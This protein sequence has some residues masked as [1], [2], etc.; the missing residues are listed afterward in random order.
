MNARLLSL[1]ECQAGNTDKKS[2]AEQQAALEFPLDELCPG[3]CR[4]LHGC[5]ILGANLHNCL[6]IWLLLAGAS[7]A[8]VWLPSQD[9]RTN[10]QPSAVR[11]SPMNLSA[12]RNFSGR[13]FSR[14]K[15]KE[16]EGVKAEGVSQ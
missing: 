5:L 3:S 16:A 7:E 15:V 6:F 9:R 2:D 1:A 13:F 14:S 8:S 4:G 12:G 11:G 10:G